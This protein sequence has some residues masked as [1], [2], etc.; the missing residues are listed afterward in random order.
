MTTALHCTVHTSPALLRAA[1]DAADDR[2][3]LRITATN[4]GPD[5]VT[6]D[7]ITVTVPAGEGAD[8]L[9]AA[10]ERITA[11]VEDRTGWQAEH[12]GGGVFR[13]RPTAPG[14]ELKPGEQVVITLQDIAVNRRVGTAT[15]GISWT[16]TDAEGI[17][18]EHATGGRKLVKA[19]AEALLEDFRPDRTI[20]PRGETVTLT[21]KCVDGPDYELFHG[22]QRETVNHCIVDG[23]G[24]WTSD[25]LSTATAFMLLASTEKDG[26]PVTYGLT[27]AVTVDVPDLEVGSLD[28]NGVVRLFGEPQAIAGGT[29]S[30]TWLYSADTDGVI[31]GYIKTNRS[32]APATLNV[33]VTPPRTKQQKYATQSW[34]ARGGTE[35][36]EASLLVPVPRGSTVR[37]VQSTGGGAFTA[38]LTWFPFGSGPLRPAEP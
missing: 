18:C 30:G 9:T 29:E 23:N 21:W 20:V 33:F 38:D 13:V 24:T 4:P 6:C 32:D 17:A 16:L 25:G 12:R 19:P 3:T 37:V 10:P 34:D 35:N 22:D 36:Q 2:A 14:T 7:T 26:V 28:A 1:T 31:T 11:R 8:A 27:T 5:A 15:L